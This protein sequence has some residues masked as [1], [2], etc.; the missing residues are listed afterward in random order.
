MGR[1]LK[2]MEISAFA[3][4]APLPARLINLMAWSMVA[5]CMEKSGAWMMLLMLG[6]WEPWG[7]D[8]SIINHFFPE[9]LLVA[10]PM[11]LMRITGNGGI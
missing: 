11:G 4:H 8:R 3:S 10:I 5:Y 2:A 6:V 7:E 9:Y 1:I